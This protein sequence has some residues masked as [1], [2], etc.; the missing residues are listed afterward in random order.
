MPGNEGVWGVV[1]TPPKRCLECESK[2]PPRCCT[3]VSYIKAVSCERLMQQHG[4]PLYIKINI[5]G[6]DIFCI[7]GI[8]RSRDL[9][10]LPKFISFEASLIYSA[11]QVQKF[12]E[13]SMRGLNRL[14]CLGYTKFKMSPQGR[15]NLRSEDHVGQSSGPFGLFALDG[16]KGL[17]WKT[18][19]QLLGDTC[20]KGDWC[21]VHA[22]LPKTRRPMPAMCNE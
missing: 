2:A 8:S 13:R 14:R 7:L 12:N 16:K 21:D 4:V 1:G 5:E 9:S 19:E 10:N 17:E 6:L 3:P 22:M 20:P 15:Y 18:Y 11:T